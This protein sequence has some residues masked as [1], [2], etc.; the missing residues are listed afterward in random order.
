TFKNTK[1]DPR[2]LVHETVHA[3]T[4][5]WIQTMPMWMVEGIADYVAAIPYSKGRFILKE[6]PRGLNDMITRKLHH[7]G[8]TAL[9]QP[10]D[11]VYL[12]HFAF[13]GDARPEPIIQLEKVE[14]TT[15]TISKKEAAS[16]SDDVLRRYS[17]SMM[18]FHHF[19][20]TDQ[21]PAMRKYLFAHLVHEAQRNQYITDYNDTLDDYNANV[22]K[23][24]D[25]FNLSVRQRNEQVIAYNAAI[26][27]RRAGN[28][29]PLPPTPSDLEAPTPLPVPEILANPKPPEWFS[30]A[31]ARKTLA[32]ENL[33]LPSRIGL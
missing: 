28:N 14:P 19:T 27:Q 11:F 9:F 22:K 10:T 30:R 7:T 29:V 32:N 5:N 17:S 6:H 26:D 24:I 2:T 1:F 3:V 23:M 21:A 18:L 12:D 33:Q 16:A 4:H 13:M 25:G 15:V 31:T 8:S 20:K